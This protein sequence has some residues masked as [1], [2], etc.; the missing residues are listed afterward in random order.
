MRKALALMVFIFIVMPRVQ[1]APLNKQVHNITPEVSTS[2]VVAGRTDTKL[3]VEPQPQEPASVPEAPVVQPVEEQPVI[4]Q[5][6]P[7]T[8]PEPT[9][10]GCGDNVYATYIYMHE[11][12]CSTT[13][14]NSIGCRGLGQSCPGDKLPCGDDYDCQNEWFSNY[15]ISRYGSWENAYYF[16]LANSWW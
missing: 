9:Q 4:T 12:H 15:A 14:V 6:V 3:P 2:K 7:E 8:P 11:S 10:T 5:V 16:W 13:A 1:A